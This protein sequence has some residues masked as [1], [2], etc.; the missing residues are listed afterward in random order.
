MAGSK[1]SEDED[2]RTLDEEA[3]HR[4]LRLVTK[5]FCREII[6][7][8]ASVRDLLKVSGHVLD[9]ASTQADR[10]RPPAEEAFSRFTSNDVVTDGN[11][12]RMGA[13]TLRPLADQDLPLVARWVVRDDIRSAL[14]VP[15]PTGEDELRQHMAGPGCSNHLI[16][17]DGE[18]AGMIG[19]EDIDRHSRRLE[20][21]KFIGEPKLRGRGVGTEATFLWLHYAFD[22]LG[23][24]KVYIHTHHGNARNLKLNRSLGFE[25]EG[26]LS[27]EHLLDGS[28]V[29]IVRMGLLRKTWKGLTG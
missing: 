27:E 23:F 7:Y 20:M 18:P 3:R 8:G 2:Y 28:F 16:L 9:F 1:K 26:V 13:T 29:D 22:G 15:Y 11:A 10:P 5:S 19:A 24:N 21:R 4:M 25:V 12:Y 14:L 6:D 17:H